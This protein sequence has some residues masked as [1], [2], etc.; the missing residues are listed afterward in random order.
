MRYTGRCSMSTRISWTNETWNPIRARLKESIERPDPADDRLTILTRPWGY[1]CERISP[2]CQHCYAERMNGRMLP[3]WGTGLD[4]TVLN[5]DKVEIFL[6]EE[7]MLKPLKWKKPRRVFPCSMTDM[8]A[9]FVPDEMID[10]V[11]AVMA[12]TPQH[13][14]QVLTKRADRMEQYFAQIHSRLPAPGRGVCTGGPPFCGCIAGSDRYHESETGYC[15]T[16]WPLANVWLGVSVEDQKRADERIPHLPRTP[17]AVRF[18]SCEP[19]LQ[20]L[21]I[22]QYVQCPFCAEFE[23]VAGKPCLCG[24]LI[25]WCITGCESGPSAR[26]CEIDW[27]RSLR[28]QCVSAGTLF[29]LKQ[30]MID[31]KKV[32]TPELDG[33][34]WLEMPEVRR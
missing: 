18:L 19:L 4:Y 11:F 17:A 30:L 29:F 20:G 31:G 34:R 5:R 14:Y 22:R 27:I 24:K 2:G 9:A 8:F 15:G 26:P 28:D 21:D 12:L 13:T 10:R 3:H 32:E 7:E 1:H 16:E 6:D 25:D 23:G 33:R